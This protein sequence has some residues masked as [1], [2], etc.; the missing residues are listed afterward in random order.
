MVPSMDASVRIQRMPIS[1]SSTAIMSAGCGLLQLLQKQ[2]HRPLTYLQRSTEI[3]TV[4]ASC[5]SPLPG[6]A[7]AHP[8]AFLDTRFNQPCDHL[9][10]PLASLPD[11]AFGKACRCSTPHSY[12]HRRMHQLAAI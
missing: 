1:I 11:C 6:A 7:S 12:Q 8:V 3:S 4:I 5:T 10:F 2:D 9:T